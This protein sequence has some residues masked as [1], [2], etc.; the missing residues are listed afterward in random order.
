MSVRS[1]QESNDRRPF[2]PL[3]GRVRV[4]LASNA[5]SFEQEQI[6]KASRDIRDSSTSRAAE[7]C[8]DCHRAA[9]PLHAS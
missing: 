2:D 1:P 9:A 5:S 7:I 3:R 8:D 4:N 6:K